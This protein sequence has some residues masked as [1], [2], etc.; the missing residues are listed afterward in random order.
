MTTKT[1]AL[2]IGGTLQS[3]VH[4]AVGGRLRAFVALVTVGAAASIGGG[5]YASVG[6]ALGRLPYGPVLARTTQ[7]IVSAL[8]VIAALNQIGVA[9]TVTEPVLITVLATIGGILVV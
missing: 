4:R 8:G 5:V 9:T 1:F 2:D 7:V 6:G 3:T